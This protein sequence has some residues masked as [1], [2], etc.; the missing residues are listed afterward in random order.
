MRTYRELFR[1]PE[2]TP[3]FAASSLQVAG[4]T[5]SGLALGT[6]IYEQTGSPLLSA[7]AMFGPSLAQVLG[8]TLLLSAADR[9]PPR[10]AMTAL[11][12][13][14]AA[15]TTA[16]AA[17]GLP[18]WGAFAI[19][20]CLG[21]LASVGGGVRAT[22]CSTRSCRATA[23]CSAGRWSTCPPAPCRSPASRSAACS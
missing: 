22:G 13:V 16:Q 18:V 3:L 19:L 6:H 9:L 7:L 11:A 21:L 2:F 8:A 17:P 1:A 14:Y 10:G 20:V 15:A 4:L 12:L 23:T 5:I